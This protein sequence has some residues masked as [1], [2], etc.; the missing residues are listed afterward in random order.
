[1]E[2]I[3]YRNELRD[4]IVTLLNRWESDE[5]QKGKANLWH[6]QFEANPH[7]RTRSPFIIL[8][9][10]GH[11]V[12]FNGSMPVTVKYNDRVMDALWSCDMIVDTKYR[13]KGHGKAL[14]KALQESA[15]LIIGIGMSDAA[16]RV[17]LKN[18]WKRNPDVAVYH[19]TSRP[20][21]SRDWVKKAVQTTQHALGRTRAPRDPSLRL[22]V[23]AA[24]DL[25]RTVDDLWKRVQGDY[26]K[27]VVRTYE[28]LHW[29]YGT[30]PASCYEAILA[31]RGEELVGVGIFRRN[32]NTSPFLDYIGPA[33]APAL[34][35]ELLRRFMKTCASARNLRCLT[36]EDEFKSVLSALGFRR[37]RKR[38][39]RF[40]IYS[41]IEGDTSPEQNWFVM[42]GDSDGDFLKAAGIW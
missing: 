21:T 8:A 7:V 33:H 12:G 30:H 11:V 23:V 6:W 27:A 38:R 22:G 31:R 35:A 10:N 4:E 29:K 28:Y 19:Y 40:F 1:M 16:L 20:Q 39:Q 26:T 14:L 17:Y 25:P 5:Y 36:T 24:A 32:R 41:N 9:E 37:Y 3:E 34:K 42:A 2:L 18:G 15:P 13:G